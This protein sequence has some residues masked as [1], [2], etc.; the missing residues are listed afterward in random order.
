MFNMTISKL[1]L[2]TP[3]VKSPVTKST[4]QTIVSGASAVDISEG[5]G[6][7]ATPAVPAKAVSTTSLAQSTS[8]SSN[9]KT[10][11][12]KQQNLSVVSRKHKLRY[13]GVQTTNIVKEVLTEM[14]SNP[15]LYKT[16]KVPN[17]TRC[18]EVFQKTPITK[19]THTRPCNRI[20]LFPHIS[21]S[22]CRKLHSTADFE[23]EF[24]SKHWFNPLTPRLET[25]VRGGV[26]FVQP[27]ETEVSSRAKRPRSDSISSVSS[28]T[29]SGSGR[30]HSTMSSAYR[31]IIN[32]RCGR[33]F[34]PKGACICKIPSR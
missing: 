24:T 18:R 22:C 23:L 9:S 13:F 16:C 15:V 29:S 12:D 4:V 31:P 5:R 6:I 33:C 17:C 7:F 21:R 8:T 19:C 11:V 20:G 32:D 3:T 1:K 34:K 2:R 14:L 27:M 25:H 28:I 30:T 26:G 10:N